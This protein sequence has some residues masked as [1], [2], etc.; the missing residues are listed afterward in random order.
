MLV[1]ELSWQE[2][3]LLAGFWQV[4]LGGHE[5]TGDL[6]VH[7]VLLQREKPQ[8][9]AEDQ[10]LAE[11]GLPRRLISPRPLVKSNRTPVVAQD[12][13]TGSPRVPTL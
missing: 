9:G 11:T 7:V 4:C 1:A 5:D 3:W 12:P 6:A 2:P 8:S 10:P 13:G